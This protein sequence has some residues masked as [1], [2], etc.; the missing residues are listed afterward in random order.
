MLFLSNLCLARRDALSTRQ[1]S[2][3]NA[4]VRSGQ[5]EL[6][7]HLV[8]RNYNGKDFASKMENAQ[9]LR[10]KAEATCSGRRVGESFT[11]SSQAST[12]A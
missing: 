10:Q 2:R 11:F 4:N 9:R 8:A 5:T 1:S 6:L 7:C 3:G 12:R